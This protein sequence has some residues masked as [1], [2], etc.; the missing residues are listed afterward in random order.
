MTKA[1]RLLR[2][3]ANLVWG[4]ALMMLLLLALY[5]GLGRQVM[6]NLHHYTDELETRI[7]DEL[8]RSVSIDRLEGDWR[9]L[10]PV[11][12]ISGLEVLE[13]DGESLAS[14]GDL[15]L[16]LDS[17]V[18]L[19]R[20]RL[21]LREFSISDPELRVVQRSD[22]LLGIDGLWQ[23]QPEPLPVPELPRTAL[24]QRLRIWFDELG[25]LLHEPS[26]QI[27][28]LNL[29][30][31]VS[32][33]PEEHFVLPQADLSFRR[34][35]FTAS[36]QLNRAGTG[37]QVAMFSLYG[38]HFF[39]GD[40][41]GDAF[42]QF[43]SERLFDTLLRRYQWQ[44]L[45]IKGVDLD[46]RAWITFN[47]GHP[48][49]GVAQLEMPF[50]S[51]AT[52]SDAM[53]PVEDLTTTLGWQRREQGW[54]LNMEQLRYHWRGEPMLPVSAQLRRDRDGLEVA[55]DQLDAGPLTRLLT[56]TGLLPERADRE[57]AE[58]DPQGKLHNLNLRLP[59]Q[60]PWRF[61]AEVGDLSVK[62]Y[63]N[64][65]AV[66]R[67][68]G[69]LE[70]GPGGGEVTLNPGP[71]GLNLPRLFARPWS[72]EHASGRVSWRRRG[73]QW[74]VQGHDLFAR[75][76][77]Q[78][79][80]S[81]GFLLRVDPIDENVLSLRVGVADGHSDLLPDLV[82][83]HRVPD[84]LY[85]FLTTRIRDTR[86]PWG[87]YYG[88]GTVQ[89]G[90]E[91]PA[92]TSAM[93]YHFE[94]GQLDY[95]DRMPPLT[96]ARGQVQVHNGSA[97]VALAEGTVAG[98]PLRPSRVRVIPSEAGPE[99]RIRTGAR[100]AGNLL[101]EDWL[102]QSPLLEV[103]G[104]WLK[105]LDLSGLLDLNLQLRVFPT[106]QRPVQL[107]LKADLEDTRLRHEPTGL[108]WES[109]GGQLNYHHRHGF[110]NSRLEGRFMG[111]PVTVDITPPGG[112]SPQSGP[113][114]ALAVKTPYEPDSG[115]GLARISQTGSLSVET[116][117]QW[118]DRPL[119]GVEGQVDYRLGLEASRHPSL[120]LELALA[121]LTSRWPAPLHK[122]PG[123]EHTVRIRG[124]SQG[125]G[126]WLF[127]GHWPQRMASRLRWQDGTLERAVV[128]L[129]E[130]SVAL[131]GSPGVHVRGRMQRLDLDQW[132]ESLSWLMPDEPREETPSHWHPGSL[133]EWFRSLDLAAGELA[134]MKRDLG[135]MTLKASRD[136]EGTWRARIDGDSALGDLVLHPDP[137]TPFALT[138]ERLSL[139][140]GE[141]P[142]A[143]G[144]DSGAEG[145]DSGAEGSDSGAEGSRAERV[146]GE[147][148]EASG[149]AQLSPDMRARIPD[150]DVRIRQLQLGEI[151]V[152]E[153][154]F[155]L[156]SSREKLALE[157]LSARLDQLVFQG[158]LE[159]SFA[160]T[161]PRTLVRGLLKGGDI[162]ALERILPQGV[163]LRSKNMG[164][165]LDFTWQGAPDAMTLETLQ[166]VLKFWLEEGR[167]LEES[168]TARIFGIFGLLN[169][170][171]LWRRLRLDFS[172]V[173]DG[174]IAFDSLEGRAL[175]A[176]G[177]LILD[178]DL[179]IHAP[180]GGFRMSGEA[181]LLDESL[182]M[183]LVVV[184]P[185]TQN[186]PLAAVL[187]GAAPVAA[188]LYLVDQ[189]FGGRL[190][191]ITSA[192][193]SLEG[194]W[195][196][197]EARLRNLFDTE[198]ELGRYKRP[199]LDQNFMNSDNQ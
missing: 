22:G 126:E 124:Q 80:F 174:G 48:I 109:L 9:G 118:L 89:P 25:R 12:K 141:A 59:D 186:L 166:G 108:L 138:L 4:L 145:S 157:S 199:D 122:L 101:S 29:T 7:A 144:S 139:P 55:V 190:S 91:H 158:G 100:V 97:Q 96:D 83:V 32:G 45:A 74:L 14:L 104:S 57:L 10:D 68:N 18:S 99:V 31:A 6:N 46:A 67:L 16:R 184:L 39:S 33:E 52:P 135:A 79:R 189:M 178:P 113:S 90:L 170:D 78:A 5:V 27:R 152:E 198:S 34:G 95:H 81:V 86:V 92:F 130:S 142:E 169:T 63:R 49:E 17:R 1:Q 161:V 196:D 50:L 165:A 121:P 133:P 94:E 21:V 54:Q 120:D 134:L 20:Q 146:P 38:Q 132:R 177:R 162:A 129:G 105:D 3:L 44:R 35:L 192:T 47:G 103:T 147:A 41:T 140:G 69:L 195:Q 85:R 102:T 137:A 179:V 65:P 159:W 30:L 24:E 28:D 40:F 61:A 15:R 87:W 11:L 106:R 111:E 43:S 53:T 60:G 88:H 167:I 73:E 160:G 180:S 127:A 183:R 164:V 175:I 197:P 131:P 19:M 37:R 191:R 119:P 36:G 64:T 115:P 153:L 62:A 93:E 151:P 181:N 71:V 182:D 66:E 98:T 42:V 185:V 176:D 156:R 172:D 77:S 116:V 168:D 23:Q 193:Y 123:K 125:Q 155:N 51:V 26:L 128:T 84:G 13:A 148:G 56:A 149:L 150:L 58:R 171:T 75:H 107:K 163:P 76:P 72:L 136:G 188:L 117:E 194:T 114:G 154:A 70:V 173:A 112:D 143:E 2:L 8:G 82:P 187:V 110:R